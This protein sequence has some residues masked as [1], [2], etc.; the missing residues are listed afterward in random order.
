MVNAMKELVYPTKCCKCGSGKVICEDFLD[1]Y[2]IWIRVECQDCH[3]F[4]N[5]KIDLTI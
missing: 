1:A 3:F 5:E 4:W 2:V